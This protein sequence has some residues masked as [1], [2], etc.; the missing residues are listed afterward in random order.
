M[1]VTQQDIL[2]VIDKSGVI[3]DVAKIKGGTNLKEVGVDSM[4][5]MNLLLAIEEKYGI[6]ISDEDADQMTTVDVIVSYLNKLK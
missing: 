2:S 3:I 5:M 4:D 6:Q 1:N